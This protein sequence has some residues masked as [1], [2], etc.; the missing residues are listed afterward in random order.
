MTKPQEYCEPCTIIRDVTFE[1]PLANPR[2][3][4]LGSGVLYK[5]RVAWVKERPEASPTEAL[6]PAYVDGVGIISLHP[7]V[8]VHIG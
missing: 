1:V 4:Q 6:V 3:P 7:H 5:G 2:N 8:L